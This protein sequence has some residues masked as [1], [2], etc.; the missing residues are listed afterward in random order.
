MKEKDRNGSADRP[1][2]V[3]VTPKPSCKLS[4]KDGNVFSV[5]GHVRRALLRAGLKAEAR[6]FVQRA[7][8]AHS[9]QEVLGLCF[10]YV[11]VR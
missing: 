2:P 6:E 10:E 9:Y 11:E 7:F 1:E 8:G 4:G 3:A 5:I